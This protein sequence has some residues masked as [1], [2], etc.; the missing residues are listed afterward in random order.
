MPNNCLQRMALRAAHGRGLDANLLC[1]LDGFRRGHAQSVHSRRKSMHLA[2][3][4]TPMSIS[5]H[6]RISTDVTVIYPMT[7]TSTMLLGFRSLRFDE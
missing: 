2:Y 5:L 7:V 6:Q 3:T 1:R 4:L